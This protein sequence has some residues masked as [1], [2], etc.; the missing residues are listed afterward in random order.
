MSQGTASAAPFAGS[1]WLWLLRAGTGDEARAVSPIDVAG[2]K[3]AEAMPWLV[4]R[5]L[6]CS[7]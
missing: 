7:V 2:L 4:G 1:R 3:R 5:D 6:R